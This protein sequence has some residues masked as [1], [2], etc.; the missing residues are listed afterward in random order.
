MYYDENVVKSPQ[1][2]VVSRHATREEAERAA[3]QINHDLSAK[4]EP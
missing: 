4:V 3:A 2:N 1:G